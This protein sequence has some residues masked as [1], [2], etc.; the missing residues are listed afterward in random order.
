M[1]KCGLLLLFVLVF[2]SGLSAQVSPD[3]FDDRIRVIFSRTYANY[4]W[5]HVE[6]GIVVCSD[7]NVYKYNKSKEELSLAMHQAKPET[8]AA[9][10]SSFGKSLKFFKTV[11]SE[12]VAEMMAMVDEVKTFSYSDKTSNGC[13]MGCLLWLAYQTEADS[14]RFATVKLKEGGDFVENSLSPSAQVIVKW[15]DE[16]SK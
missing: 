2:A 7:G 10:K 12:K 8:M 9:L 16:L 11:A 6:Q 3:F 1:K 14:E 4:A 5:E 15:L 13:D